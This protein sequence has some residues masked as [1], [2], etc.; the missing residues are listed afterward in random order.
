MT[1]RTGRLPTNRLAT[2]SWLKHPD[3]RHAF[4]LLDFGP[5]P[6]VLVL[7]PAYPRHRPCR[8]GST[9]PVVLKEAFRIESPG[10]RGSGAGPG[11]LL[12][13]QGAKLAVAVAAARG[14]LA[15]WSRARTAWAW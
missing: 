1:Q 3:G 11:Q 14:L 6:R 9:L 13:M 4:C 8:A 10:G 5:C 15:R 2:A 7:G 12:L